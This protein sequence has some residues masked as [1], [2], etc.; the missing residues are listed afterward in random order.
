GERAATLRAETL[1]LADLNDRSVLATN[2]AAIGRVV[3]DA[4]WCQRLQ[5]ILRPL[6]QVQKSLTETAKAAS[7]TLLNTDFESRFFN[8]CSA[9]RP[10]D[11]RLDFPGGRGEAKRRKGVS[12]RKPSEVLS[13]GEQKVLV[14]ADFLAEAGL[15]LSSA[16][17]IFDDPVNSL[18]Y[19]RIHE[20]ADRV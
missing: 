16:P 17:V 9:L 2:I 15:G 5:Q 3:A 4:K 1:R 11:V 19:R 6:H 13:E 7:D 10:L 14:L 12:S 20:V 8:E 18:D